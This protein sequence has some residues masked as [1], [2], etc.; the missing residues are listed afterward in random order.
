M[1]LYDPELII[2]SLKT[3]TEYNLGLDDRGIFI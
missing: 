3:R 2:K 1:H